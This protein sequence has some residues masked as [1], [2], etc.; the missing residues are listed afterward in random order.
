MNRLDTTKAR[1]EFS[2]T[3]NRVAYGGERIVLERRGKAVVAMVS[4]TD[5]ANLE[6]PPARRAAS[7]RSVRPRGHDGEGDCHPMRVGHR[8]GAGRALRTGSARSD[9]AVAPREGRGSTAAVRA[10]R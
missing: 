2:D 10:R 4:M 3:I 7:R 9:D 1:E 6:K 8:V 5:L